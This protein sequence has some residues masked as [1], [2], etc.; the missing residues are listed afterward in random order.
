MVQA[1]LI[2]FLLVAQANLLFGIFAIYTKCIIHE[3]KIIPKVFEST[4]K[5]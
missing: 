5:T 4:V 1:I 3:H 2:S